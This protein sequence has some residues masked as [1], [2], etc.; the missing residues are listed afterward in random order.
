MNAP[1]TPTPAASPLPALATP[2]L[3]SFHSS[4]LRACS[5]LEKPLG[6]W[7]G[8]FDVLAR[9]ASS[10]ANTA[11]RWQKL[12]AAEAARLEQADVA[13]MD[14]R[15]GPQT[16]DDAQFYAAPLVLPSLPSSSASVVPD[17]GVLASLPGVVCQLSA[18]HE[19]QVEIAWTL[20]CTTQSVAREARM[21]ADERGWRRKMKGA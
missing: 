11:P 18:A 7:R 13:A 1:P 3:V 12:L 16:T 9:V 2:A 8:L 17:L 6:E 15:T 5:A 20:L 14:A 21:A 19:R 4:L 10:L